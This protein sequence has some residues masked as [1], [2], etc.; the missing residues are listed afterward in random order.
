MRD[1]RTPDESG[2]DTSHD[3]DD[4]VEPGTWSKGPYGGDDDD[5][6]ESGGSHESTGTDGGS[7]GRLR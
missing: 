6:T 4:G 7:D 3:R 2:R 5:T 1:S